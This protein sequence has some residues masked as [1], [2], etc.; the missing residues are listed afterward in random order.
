MNL[1]LTNLMAYKNYFKDIAEKHVDVDGFKWGNKKVLLNDNKSNM[2]KSIIWALP[3]EAAKY[4]GNTNTHKKKIARVSYLEVRDSKL[5]TDEDEQYVRCE[6][7]IEEV[8]ARILRD[9]SGSMVGGE[10]TMIA[11]SIAS[12]ETKPIENFK[13]GSTDYLGYELVMEFLD[14]TNLAFKKEKWNDTLTT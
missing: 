14:N 10:W 12:W 7:H 13:L 3:Y 4:S 8:I 2:P 6:E 9:K 11:T 1:L 5:F